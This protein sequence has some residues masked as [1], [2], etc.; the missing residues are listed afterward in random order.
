[1]VHPGFK[2]IRYKRHSQEYVWCV[3]D[4]GA[5]RMWCNVIYLSNE[6][7]T[8]ARYCWW[9]ARRGASHRAAC[10]ALSKERTLGLLDR[11]ITPQQPLISK[12]AFPIVYK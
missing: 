2:I 5:E 9:R 4:R 12:G 11:G 6:W 1:M 3:M 7:R 8:I 10:L